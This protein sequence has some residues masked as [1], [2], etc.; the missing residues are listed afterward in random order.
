MILNKI[1]NKSDDLTK[2]DFET[3]IFDIVDELLLKN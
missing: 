2:K 1:E 3:L